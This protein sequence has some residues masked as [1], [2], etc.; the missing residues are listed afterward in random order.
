MGPTAS[1]KTDFSLQL[2][3]LFPCEIISVDSAMIYRG[4]NI[5]TAKPSEE[6]LARVPHKLIDIRD[7]KESYSAGEFR[8]DALQ[9]I[10]EMLS[11]GKTPLLVGG[12][13]MYFRVLQ[14][15]IAT[16]PKADPAIREALTVRGE[17]EGWHV[18][19]AELG[20]VDNKAADKIHPEDS[21][22]IQRALE[23]F[24]LTGQTISS[25][26]QQTTHPLSPYRVINVALLP[27]D[28]AK[29]HA[30]IAERFQT[31]LDQ[32]FVA[33]VEALYSRGDLTPKLP[34]IRSVGYH[35]VWEYL[36]GKYSYDEM[37]DKAIAA[38]RQLAKRQLTWLRSWPGIQHTIRACHPE[39]S[40]GSPAS[41]SG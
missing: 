23:V 15:G 19:H 1:G 36:E 40:E 31:M 21:Q 32:G 4:M 20:M 27:E 37:R 35:Q 6:L 13:M 34:S 17:R 3:S 22:R 8:D 18:L 12:T 26:Q 25:L 16:L 29:L 41:S 9:A 2:A 11:R 5:G 28:R 30:R 24:M 10:E 14:Q 33:E 39:R 7:P 38:T